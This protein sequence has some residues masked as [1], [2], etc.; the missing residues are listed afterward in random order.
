VPR[1]RGSHAHACRS[2]SRQQEEEMTTTWSTWKSFPN[3]RLGGQLEAPIGPGIYE[4]RDASSNA[5][6]AFDSSNSVARDLAR[7]LPGTPRGLIASLFGKAPVIAFENLEYRT[8]ASATLADAHS[9]AE[10]LRGRREAFMR[11]RNHAWG[12]A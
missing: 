1:S 2:A 8:W 7:L 4:V 12:T 3:P 10:R 11:R 9:N 6:V 5:M